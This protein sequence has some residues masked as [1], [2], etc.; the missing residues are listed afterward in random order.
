MQ[1]LLAVGL[2]G[3]IGSVAR[4]LLSGWVLH[5]AGGD[6]PLGTLAVN[7]LG[8]LAIGV[9][10]GLAERYHTLTPSTRIFLITGILGGFT[11]FSA[12]GL[13]TVALLR[14]GV[15]YPAGLNIIANVALGILAVWI[16]LRIV[17]LT[18]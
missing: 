4:Y 16:G 14:R 15:L 9:L 1:D 10:A 8:C 18:R 5:R 17:E 3:M 12:F 7:S 2:G 6:F 11:T 13:E